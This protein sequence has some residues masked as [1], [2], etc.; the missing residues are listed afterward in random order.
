MDNF[1]SIEMAEMAKGISSGIKLVYFILVSDPGY[2]KDK[3]LIKI[4]CT[5]DIKQRVYNLTQDLGK[6]YV[7]NVYTCEHH[8][9]F[10][11]LLHH[12]ASK[13]RYHGRV[14][15]IRPT[16]V[17]EVDKEIFKYMQNVATRNVDKFRIS[18][19]GDEHV[20]KVSNRGKS[21]VNGRKIQKYSP[22]G[23]LVC[24]YDQVST[25]VRS[26]PEV[27]EHSLRNACDQK[28]I[29]DGHRWA[30]LARTE[31][32]E[33]RQD[34]G[35]TLV[36]K[37]PHT[38]F[39]VTLDSSKRRI[40][41]VYTSMK[42]LAEEEDTIMATSISKRVKKNKPLDDGRYVEHWPNLDE[43]QKEEWLE[44]NEM[45]ELKTNHM[46]KPVEKIDIVTGDVINT[47]K[48]SKEVYEKYKIGKHSLQS[49]ISSGTPKKGFIWKFVEK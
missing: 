23:E 10:E 8:F 14:N 40:I 24:T 27:K 21:T 46:S 20:E 4:G 5:S 31:D 17:F 19:N 47:Y 36:I 25:A 12:E 32:D 6:V 22:D 37:K 28:T 35:K 18:S 44:E 3:F 33:T 15:G 39:V 38:G 16:E 29:L 41:D 45:P 1:S 7:L 49:A 13:Y 48:T 34:I 2:E 9:R 26:S 30:Y 11:K 42:H 43:E